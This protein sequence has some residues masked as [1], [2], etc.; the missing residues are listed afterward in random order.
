MVTLLTMVTMVKQLCATMG[1]TA[2]QISN[3]ALH[4]HTLTVAQVLCPPQ[5]FNARHFGTAEVR[6]YILWRPGHFQ[7]YDLPAEFHKNL[8]VTSKV[9]RGRHKDN[10]VIS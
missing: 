3:F 1:P 6:D 9:I 10:M 2:A 7:W 4:S 8:P 5:N